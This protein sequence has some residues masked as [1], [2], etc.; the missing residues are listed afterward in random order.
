[1]TFRRGTNVPFAGYFDLRDGRLF[2]GS[3]RNNVRLP[4]YERLDMRATRS[5]TCLSRKMT[6]FAEVLNVLNRTNLRRT[7]GYIRRDTGEAIGFTEELF[8]RL[9]SAGIV[10]EF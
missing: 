3:R 1:M 5:F 9:P 7:N 8:P 10:V 6:V 2:A 4:R